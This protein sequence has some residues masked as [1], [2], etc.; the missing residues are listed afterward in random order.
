[1]AAEDEGPEGGAAKRSPSGGTQFRIGTEVVGSDGLCGDL[2]AVIIAP[3][4]GALTHL[5]VKPEHHHAFGRLV[6]IEMVE[7]DGDPIV[8][9]IN[10]AQFEVLEDAEE[11]EL[12]EPSGET[13]DY[14]GG[15]AYSWPHYGLGLVGGMGAG[16]M[17]DLELGHHH[18]PQPQLT[19]RVPVGEV[20]IKR[21]DHVHASDG[22]IGSVEGLVIDPADHHVTHVLLA[23]GHLWGRKQ[24]AI[25][26]GTTARV[27]DEIRVDLTKEQVKDLPP[28]TLSSTP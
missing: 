6:P 26:I 22:W 3:V 11:T 7:S 19:D 8:L 5:V 28:V 21:G 16:G 25:P 13:W 10:R 23:E 27:G 9:R 12:V 14:G 17:G 4:A 18:G 15:E 2:I 24:V 1:M 20:E